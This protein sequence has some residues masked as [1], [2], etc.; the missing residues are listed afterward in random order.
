LW[1]EVTNEKASAR[2]RSAIWRVPTCVEHQPIVQTRGSQLALGPGL[3]VDY[4]EIVAWAMGFGSGQAHHE[5]G[6]WS[7]LASASRDLLPDWYDEW[8]LVE[9]ERFRQLRLH[10]LETAGEL[11]VEE[12]N[13]AQALMA[14]LAA[15]E[16]EPL[17]ESTHRLVIRAHIGEGNLYEAYRQYRACAAVLKSEL[18]IG[19]S[20]ATESLVAQLKGPVR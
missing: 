9:R 3:Q 6:S 2:L 17:R 12:G 11:L 5:V 1:P 4:R 20:L 15:V 8:V 14:G 19:P 7:L 18:G 13:Y 16:A 10:A